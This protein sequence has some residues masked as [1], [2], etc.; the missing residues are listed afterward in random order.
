MEIQFNMNE[1][2][3][4]NRLGDSTQPVLKD[5]I[6]WFVWD[7]LL[8]GEEVSVTVRNRTTNYRVAK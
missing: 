8:N 1:G 7:D 4:W 3:G 6:G 2:A 5:M